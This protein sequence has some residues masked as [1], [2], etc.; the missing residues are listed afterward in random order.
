MS[1]EDEAIT[2]EALSRLRA[3]IFLE[4]MVH[5][6]VAGKKITAG[7]AH[8]YILDCFDQLYEANI[9]HYWASYLMF[10]GIDSFAACENLNENLGLNVKPNTVR[11]WARRSKP[12]IIDCAVEAILS[13]MQ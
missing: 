1:D 5:A 6:K 12:K 9:K 4:V 10:E 13:D 8:P 2:V 7:E 3:D 11:V